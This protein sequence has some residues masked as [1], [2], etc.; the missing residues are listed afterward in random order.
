MGGSSLEGAARSEVGLS[1]L[2]DQERAVMGQKGSAMQAKGA[3]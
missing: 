3:A 2:E 1:L